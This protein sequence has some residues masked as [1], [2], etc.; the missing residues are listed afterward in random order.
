MLDSMVTGTEEETTGQGPGGRAFRTGTIQVSQN[1]ETDPSFRRWREAA[2]VEDVHSAAAVPLVY[3]GTAY[4]VLAVYASRPLAFSQREQRGFEILGE[5]IG[6]AINASKT[7]ELLF[8][9]QV[10]ELELVFTNAK[11]SLISISNDLGCSLRLEGYVATTAGDW[12]LYLTVPGDKADRF[13]EAA[14]SN[15][16]VRTVKPLD[17]DDAGRLVGLTLESS[18]LDAVAAV[19]GNLTAAS[20]ESGTGRLTVEVPHSTDVRSFLDQVRAVYPDVSLAARTEHERSVTGDTWLSD[21]RGPALTDRQ[22]QALE[23]AFRAGY[24]E[25]PRES[26]AEEVAE[27]LGIAR[28]TL[29]AHLRKAECKLL[30]AFFDAE[31]SG[32]GR[33]TGTGN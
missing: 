27:L 23:A 2:T 8:A 33:P 25:W 14:L 22:R 28:P 17:G 1:I 7:R 21:D 30:T 24:F 18:L 19:G 20:L 6:Y 32:G 13:V 11:T 29:H 15:D 9:E 10:I 3:D 16:H 12:L 5:A 4:G 31:Q 26:S